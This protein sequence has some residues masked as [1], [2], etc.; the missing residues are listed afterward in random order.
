MYKLLIL[1]LAISL[2]PACSSKKITLVEVDKSARKMYL[3]RHGKIIKKYDIAL[4][5]NPR[6]H[7]IREGD[8]KTPEGIYVLDYK[9][10]H[11]KFYKSMHLSYPNY[12][13]QLRAKSIKASAGG[14]IVIHGMPNGVSQKSIVKQRG[15]DWTNGCIAVKNED[16]Q[17]FW[18]LVRTNTP[19][20]IKP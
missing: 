20:F 11:S 5:G 2:L 17:E 14:A 16:M 18:S 10:R 7:K 3:K 1:V 15:H 6:G 19:I 12:L 9:N 4:G 8:N 13:D